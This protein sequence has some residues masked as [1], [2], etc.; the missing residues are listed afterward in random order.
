MTELQTM[1]MNAIADLQTAQDTF[2][3][4]SRELDA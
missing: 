3:E 1:V 4:I 2:I